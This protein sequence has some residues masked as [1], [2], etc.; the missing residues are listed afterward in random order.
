MQYHFI[1]P[2][3]I[4]KGLFLFLSLCF[5][6]AIP[7]LFLSL[8]LL[9]VRSFLFYSSLILQS[10]FGDLRASSSLRCPLAFSRSVIVCV[11]VRVC[12]K[13]K[14]LSS[15]APVTLSLHSEHGTPF[16]RD[17]YP[18]SSSSSS[19]SHSFCPVPFLNIYF[20]KR[21]TNNLSCYKCYIIINNTKKSL[22][23]AL[24]L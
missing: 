23:T 8:G 15:C 19:S 14:G 9:C 11:C 7:S 4:K 6:F 21:K 22:S 18:P 24:K 17:N 16:A 2:R 20:Q 13:G 3:G 10:G 1:H 12:V 5:F